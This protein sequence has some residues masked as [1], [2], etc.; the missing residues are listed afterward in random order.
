MEDNTPV[1][2]TVND[3]EAWELLG[4][5]S[6]GHIAF[7]IGD[8]PEVLP[9]NY[10]V[11]DGE[12]LLRTAPGTK[13]FGVTVNPRVALESEWYDAQGGWSVVV[14]GRATVLASSAALEEA[15]AAGLRPWVPTVKENVV[16]ISVEQITGRRFTFGPEP[17]AQP[18]TIA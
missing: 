5:G 13:L 3:D 12:L 1:I 7:I 15:A 11:A 2:S 18:E 8:Q 6:L 4:S 9:V 10:A 16:R 14:K 17:E